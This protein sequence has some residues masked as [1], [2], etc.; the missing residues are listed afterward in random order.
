[1]KRSFSWAVPVFLFVVVV[2][3][4]QLSKWFFLSHSYDIVSGW[5]SLSPSMNT[6]SAFGL[7]QW[8]P[9][10][11]FVLLSLAVLVAGV[12]LVWRK[13]V[14]WLWGTL[15]LSGVAGNLVSRLLLG[16]VVDFVAFSF[17]PSFNI[18]DAVMVVSVA[19]IVWEE[20]F[21]GKR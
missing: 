20:V 19:G 14:S 2:F 4:D 8:V 7:F 12:V 1:M 16:G 5:F 18:A 10:W 11:A 17:F 15:F 6:G 21:A 13:D 9:N 3:L